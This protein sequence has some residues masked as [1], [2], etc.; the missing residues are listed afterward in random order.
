MTPKELCALLTMDYYRRMKT[1]F[2]I[3][4]IL[5]VIN[6][7]FS[8]LQNNFDLWIIYVLGVIAYL[9]SL[10]L[11]FRVQKQNSALNFKNRCCEIDESFFTVFYEDGSISKLNYAHYIKVIKKSNYYFL[12]I[13]KA[14][15]HYIPIAA[16]ES[17]KDIH[18]FELFLQ[19]K[20]LMKLW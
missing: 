9:L 20:Q 8:L 10:P 4:S 6:I 16:F 5:L 2:I 17:E 7:I 13:T 12:Y 14:Q 1:V 11:F 18:R 19:G 3:L 15:F